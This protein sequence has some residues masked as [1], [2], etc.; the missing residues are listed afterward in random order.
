MRIPARLACLALCTALAGCGGLLKSNA[1]PVQV[2]VLR[3]AAVAAPAPSAPV[4][5]TL[6]VARPAV[7]PGLAS[8]RIA[9]T[10]PGN[11]LDHFADASWGATLAQ[12]AGALA[13]ESLQSSGRFEVVADAASA[14]GARLEL[15]LTVRHFEA[16]YG[17]DE[18]AAPDARVAFE[19]LLT[20][21]TPRNVLG[22]C[23][24]AAVVPA[25]ANR[26]GAIVAALEQAAQQALAE[27]AEKAA[28]VAGE[29]G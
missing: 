28:A 7:Q 8:T 25:T 2:Y 13:V 17:S 12:V 9:L 4:A 20:T 24:G 19:C 1:P 29:V 18:G 27:V 26:L 23:D 16:E 3:P 15:Q 5:G 11:R 14:G 6:I 22:R 10:R 21:S